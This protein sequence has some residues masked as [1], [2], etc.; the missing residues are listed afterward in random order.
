MNKSKEI[1][2]NLAVLRSSN[3]T[4]L[5]AFYTCLGLSFST[6]RHGKGPEHWAAEM[7]GSVFEIYPATPDVPG[8]LGTRIG[9]R[10]PSIDDVIRRLEGFPGSVVSP[11]KDSE[12]G[13]R[14]V[15]VD[16]DG[17]KVELLEGGKY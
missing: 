12:W 14:A 16:P 4:R 8:T 2:L 10:V 11:S 17:H 5:V 13:R 7:A 9:F 6:H 1:S 15:L 3:P